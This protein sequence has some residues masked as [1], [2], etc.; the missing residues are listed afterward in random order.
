[1]DNCV[2]VLC[3]TLALFPRLAD[4]RQST[5]GNIHASDLWRDLRD[6]AVPVAVVIPESNWLRLF[7]V[8]LF[9]K[10]VRKLASRRLA[11]R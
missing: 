6:F 4:G 5:H 1:M 7:L 9:M 3:D 8:L 11:A 10:Q 2:C